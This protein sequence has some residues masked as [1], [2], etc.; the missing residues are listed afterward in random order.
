MDLADY[1]KVLIK[2]A[3][4]TEQ[5]YLSKTPE[6]QEKVLKDGLKEY[7]KA[8]KAQK[9]PANIENAKTELPKIKELFGKKVLVYAKGVGQ[10][11]GIGEYLVVGY[12]SDKKIV[13]LVNP[14]SSAKTIKVYQAEEAAIITTI[15]G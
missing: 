9:K 6:E 15:E 8:R 5:E 3:K 11:T 10:N 2:N 14:D 12:V 4:I 1:D 13:L 7:L